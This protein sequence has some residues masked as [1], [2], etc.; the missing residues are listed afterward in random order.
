[1]GLSNDLISQFAKITNDTKVKQTESTIY[2][3]V[4][5]LDGRPWV[6][7]DGSDRLTP[8]DTTAAVADGERV[9]VT[10]KNH[11]ATI[12]GNVSSPAARNKDVSELSGKIDEFDT[13]IAD[14]VKA[15]TAHIETAIIT[16]LDGKYATFEG[17]DAKYAS[18]TSLEAAEADI[19]TLQANEIVINEKLTARDAEIDQLKAKSLTVE[20]ADAK[21]ATIDNLTGTNAKLNNLESTYGEFK[22]AT[23]D[24]LDAIEADIADLDVEKLDAKYATVTRLQAAEAEIDTLQANMLVAD[25]LKALEADIADLNTNKLSAKDADIKYA[26]IAVLQSD[27]ITAA[28]IAAT[29]ITASAVAAKYAEISTLE[30]DYIKTT[31]LK[32]N[33]ITAA[34]IN[35]KYAE[36]DLANVDIA[37]IGTVL[38]NIG[39]ITSATIVDGHVTG[40][41]DSVE[42]NANN[43]TAGTLTVDR[44]II[45]G[46]DKSIIYA[47]N[48]AGELTSTET[49]TI[50]GDVITKRTIAADHIIAGTITSNEIHSSAVTADKIATNA[51][52][53][54]KIA[55]N[56]ITSGK[57][58]ANAITADK[59]AADAVTADKINVVDLKA[60]G[61][62]IGTFNIGEKSIYSGT[63]STVSNTSRGIYMDTDGQ[64]NLGDANNYLKFYKDQNNVYK[65]AIAAE[66]LTFGASGTRIEDAFEE[67][68]NSIDDIQANTNSTNSA[69]GN[70]PIIINDSAD[71]KVID[72]KV[73]G[74]TTQERKP[75]KNILNNELNIE[76]FSSNT[77]VTATMQSDKT[78]LLKG[79]SSTV[80]SQYHIGYVQCKANQTYI[81][82]GCP[83]MGGANCRLWME[84]ND[85][86]FGDSDYGSGVTFTAPNYDAEIEVRITIGANITFNNHVLKPMVRLASET[87]A[88]YEPYELSPTPDNP[89]PLVSI[90]DSGSFNVDVYGKN[91]F[92]INGNVNVT[93]S[94]GTQ[95]TYNSVSGNVLTCNANSNSVHAV[96]QKFKVNI[97]D[98][99]TFSAKLSSLGSGNAGGLFIYESGGY[100]ACLYYNL[101]EIGKVTYTAKT[102]EL[103]CAFVT[104]S[105]T[106]AQFTNIQVE[107][108]DTATEY[109]SFKKQTLSLPYHLRGVGDVKDEIDF[110]RGV[111]IQRFAEV[112]LG[113]L[114]WY[115]KPDLCYAVVTNRG[116]TYGEGLCEKYLVSKTSNTS[117]TCLYVAYTYHTNAIN[118]KN[119]GYTDAATLKVDLSGVKLVY[120]LM[121]PIE[122]PLT[123]QVLKT[124]ANL[125]TYEPNT[126]LM[127]D[128]SPE[129]YVEY[130]K[131]T[132][133]GK[134][135]AKNA[136]NINDTISKVDVMY[137]QNTSATTAPTS[138]WT[139][140]AP[141]WTDGKYIWTKT[142][143]TYVSGSTV[144]STPVCITGAKGASGKS[145]G[146]FR[147]TYS[148]TLDNIK[149]WSQKT[150]DTWNM[151]QTPVDSSG[152]P[153][154]V[155]DAFYATITCTDDGCDYAIL[156]HVRTAY[157]AGATSIATKNASGYIKIGNKGS[158][159]V[160]ISSI[161]ELYYAGPTTT[162]PAAPTAAVTTNNTSTY[163]S[164]NKA[165]P[166]YS[167]SYPHYFTCS[168]VYYTDGTYKWT[169]PVYAG[170]LTSANTTAN[171]AVNKV[172][173]LQ[174]GSRNYI[175]DS[176]K[177]TSAGR[178]ASGITSSIVD[179]VWKIVTTSGSGNYIS[180]SK[181]NTIEANFSTGDVFTFS[182]EI[183]CDPGSTGIPSIY[184]K[185]GMG[186]YDMSGTVST[187]YSTIYYTGTWKDTNDISFHLGWSGT[188]G[189]F[190]IRRMKFERGNKATD[191]TPAPEDVDA[192]INNIQVGGRNLLANSANAYPF[193]GSDMPGVSSIDSNACKITTLT[194]AR[195]NAYT[196]ISDRFASMGSAEIAQDI[197]S[198]YSFS[199]D[200]RLTGNFTN[201]L[202]FMNIRNSTSPISFPLRLD[203]EYCTTYDRWVRVCATSEVINVTQSTMKTL[204]GVSWDSSTVG[205][206]VEIKNLKLEK[207]NKATDWTPAPEDVDADISNAAKTA[208]NH[209]N[210]TSANGLIISQDATANAGNVQI[211][212]DGFRIRN[213]TT[214]N[215]SFLGNTITLG[216]NSASSS[217]NLCGDKGT[218]KVNTNQFNR[219]AL[220]IMSEDIELLSDVS[221]SM[222]C[223]PDVASG[224][225]SSVYSYVH[226]S[227]ESFT[228]GG[229]TFK[230]PVS[231]IGSYG[232]YNGAAEQAIV[233]AGLS[234]ASLEGISGANRSLLTVSDEGLEAYSTSIVKLEVNET[235]INP[236]IEIKPDTTNNSGYG[237]IYM[238]ANSIVIDPIDRTEINSKLTVSG[239]LYANGN[240]VVP[241]TGIYYAKSSSGDLWDMVRLNVANATIFGTSSYYNKGLTWLSGGD[242]MLESAIAGTNYRPYY[243]KGDS[244]ST[245]WFGAGFISASMK[246]VY[247]SIPLAKP[248]IGNP[249][250]TVTSVGGITARQQDKYL[251]GSTSSAYATPSS[252]TA[253]IEG[254]SFIRVTATMP[255]TTN[256]TYNNAPCGIDANIKITFS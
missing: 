46:S 179:G 32:A 252:Y 202:V 59:I 97:G 224:G 82:S 244:V 178:A 170:A 158:T 112:D 8:A 77:Y 150:S 157:S 120:E 119:S 99:I 95:S 20:V 141:T 1:M 138:G 38:A 253:V 43:I 219:D 206:T 203:A 74:K 12:T 84:L 100:V 68:Q 151:V 168:Q 110:D 121:T 166:T 130:F 28:E 194:S 111:Y 148:T 23:V 223:K 93:G 25:D 69:S 72:L 27:Y 64:V 39:L 7:F 159:G 35:S 173:N 250:V 154:S 145:I 87:D 189:T 237:R 254:T 75:G 165:M 55:A 182:I 124:Y 143:T 44:L 211:K 220:T 209:L 101:N 17:L 240:V 177:F 2:G 91:L 212:S 188:V 135:L 153:L 199:C 115:Y 216:Q 172:N 62:T 73:Y 50:D 215:A 80:P 217:I 5:I 6:K 102:E 53:A 214:V 222:L 79:T 54:D 249:T 200:V 137:A 16:K 205:S 116:K 117:K 164:W 131:N 243:R 15:E 213:G 118:I 175:Q 169:T 181:P 41:L 104:R 233:E 167:A 139:T 140:T 231:R 81:L 42:V 227:Y 256:V 183:K 85:S 30:S 136:D 98:T 207:G 94:D 149:N 22:I 161:T 122:I 45:S 24:R 230:Y 114:T 147:S 235:G 29:Y 201:L 123:E 60:L 105:G 106:G 66:S 221:T 65:L 226:T 26:T 71:G 56:A 163:V 144:E 234:T 108:G 156:L 34:M 132:E 103:I 61:A 255:N 229:L 31:D 76:H 228:L 126:T 11:T 63:K 70:T 129:M 193:T 225:Y 162:A 109:E 86:M 246:T 107:Y 160:G 21:Y 185:S 242:L 88:T 152:Q 40:Y 33:Y 142:V 14:T 232:I 78:V 19:D 210:F 9:M 125:R 49:D 57:I 133:D 171:N 190:Y 13:V 174:V 96:G 83:D 238:A 239:S 197:G 184:F 134:R 37:S 204:F 127:A 47:I 248:V 198:S 192:T 52:T 176:D 18:I 208:T 196:W 236:Y 128:G 155:G 241:N 48:N 247:F 89:E 3:T 113:E 51:V 146:I 245:R 191:W 180:W 4:S 218:I 58:A 186:Y 195:G 187:S 67:V 36:I 251:Y 10:V 92:D 90:G